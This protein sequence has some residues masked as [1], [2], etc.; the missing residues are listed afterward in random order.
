MEKVKI[1]ID[2][3]GSHVAIGV[4]NTEGKILEQYEKDFTTKE[5]ENVLT[6]AIR[7]IVDTIRELKQKYELLE[8]G[9]GMAGAIRNGVILR[10]VNLGAENYDIKTELE[11]KTGLSVHIKNDAKCAAI[12]EYKY[13]GIKN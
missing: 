1:G 5:K 10:S 8:F 4:V 11:N 7:Y 3:G 6:V 12:A 13:G 2:L 9:I